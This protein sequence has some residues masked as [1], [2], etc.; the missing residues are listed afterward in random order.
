[1]RLPRR[2]MMRV[3]KQGLPLRLLKAR[4]REKAKADFGF[5]NLRTAID[6]RKAFGEKRERRMRFAVFNR[7]TLWVAPYF[8][9]L[10]SRSILT[11][12]SL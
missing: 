5:I 1:M 6:S 11:F 12:A 8:T 4:R 3:C 2:F 9:L 7:M 10:F